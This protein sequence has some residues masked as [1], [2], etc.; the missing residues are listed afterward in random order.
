MTT[1]KQSPHI[2]GA[3]TRLSGYYTRGR[4]GLSFPP[5]GGGKDSHA[6]KAWSVGRAERTEL[7][8]YLAQID[9]ENAMQVDCMVDPR[10]PSANRARQ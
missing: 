7:A 2:Y 10:A 1:S 3:G 5:R 9:Q 6:F 8:K 4:N